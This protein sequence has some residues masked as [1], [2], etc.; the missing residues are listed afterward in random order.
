LKDLTRKIPIELMVL[1]QGV[2]NYLEF[3]LRVLR[4]NLAKSIDPYK[5]TFAVTYKCNSRC[6]MCNIWRRES[7]NELRLEEIEE[8]FQ[9]NRFLWLNLTGGEPF[10]RDDL[11]D[12]VRCA[13]R[14][15]LVNTT[16]NGFLTE[17]VVEFAKIMRR[18]TTR[19][20]VTVSIDGPKEIHDYLRG[21]QIWDRAIE[22]LRALME[23]RIECYVGYTATPINAGKL[24]ETYLSIKR[25]IEEFSYRQ[26]HLNFYHESEVYYD[27]VGRMKLDL[28]F[29]RKL[30]RDVGF[31]VRHRNCLDP[32]TLLERLYL[33]FIPSF[34]QMRKMPLPCRALRTSLFL[35]PFGNVF[36]CTNLNFVLG[37]LRKTNFELK[38]I[39]DS[40]KARRILGHIDS[41][42]CPQC[43][44]PCEAYQTILGNVLKVI[45]NELQK[46]EE[47]NRSSKKRI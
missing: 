45:F 19:L 10:L 32:I 40:L 30:F 2:F 17:R 42:N 11:V 13:R 12:I 3:L 14:P 6:K 38:P 35:D 29:Y 8:F 21:I 46:E 39:L 4:S 43:W 37:N 27:N 20:I 34:L 25:E 5:L 7:R 9:K 26:L 33:H 22:T 16:T 23:S 44:T 31:L 47:Q 24:E 36:P 1:G 41:G 15:L 28:D 18:Y